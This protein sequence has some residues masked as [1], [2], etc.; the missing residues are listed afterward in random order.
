MGVEGD[1][2]YKQIVRD[3]I[4]SIGEDIEFKIDAK[5]ISTIYLQEAVK[6]LRRSFYD[7]TDPL[8]TE[9]TQFNKVLGGLFRKMKSQSSIGNYDM[10]GGLALKGQVDMIKDD[11]V[12]I[13]RSID[14]FPENPMPVDILY[15][16]AC[17]WMFE[18][19]E[20]VIVYITPD[21]KEDSFVTNRNQRMFEEVIRR[22][23]VFHDLLNE[24]K[25]PIIEPSTDCQDCQYYER[26]YIRKKEGKTITISSLFGRFGK[27]DTI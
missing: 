4:D 12:L 15:V 22:T 24:K 19:I 16:N 3:A 25:V 6:C 26:C 14:K 5:D 23:K 8:E 1:R 13:F 7:R 17:M 21:G 11:V 20:G 2:D 10:D 18:K 9:Q 27:E